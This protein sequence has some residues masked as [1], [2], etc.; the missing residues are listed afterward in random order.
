[1]LISVLIPCFN[2]KKTI[3]EIVDRINNLKNINIEIIII[4]DCSNDGTV[5]ILKNKIRD[6]VSKIIFNES[7]FGKGYSLKKGIELAKGE[8]I[9]IQDADLEYDPN[10]YFKLTKPIIDGNADV[11]YGSRFIGGDERRILFFWHTIANKLLTLLSNMLT[12]LNLT[13]ME[14][15][16][17]V[18]KREIL[19]NVNLKENGF[20]FDPEVTAKVAKLKPKIYEVGISY[21]GRTYDQGKKIGL[22]D[23]FIVLKCIILY[24]LF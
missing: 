19:K 8:I 11:V 3:E 4:D 22:K 2:E 7:N 23:A 14:T 5:E 18:F 21:F 24:N 17:K 12:N 20:G 9:L 10:E 16:Y 1:M 13:D 6:K 15:C